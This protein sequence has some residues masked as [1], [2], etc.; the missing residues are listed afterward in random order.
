MRWGG[1]GRL[2]ILTSVTVDD[3]MYL[4]DG[5]THRIDTPLLS[6]RN[7]LLGLS[8]HLSLCITEPASRTIS[9]P[10]DGVR[11]KMHVRKSVH[12]FVKQSN[13]LADTHAH[14]HHLRTIV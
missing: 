4:S 3:F 13:T 6:A 5:D 14:D 11:A 9:Q 1:K 7:N 12:L 10:T 8:T 2:S